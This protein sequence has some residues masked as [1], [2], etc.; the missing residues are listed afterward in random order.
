MKIELTCIR[1]CQISGIGVIE[2]DAVIKLDIDALTPRIKQ[3]FTGWQAYVKEKE[4]RAPL[5]PVAPSKVKPAV[6]SATAPAA[7]TLDTTNEGEETVTAATMETHTDV[8]AATPEIETSTTEALTETTTETPSD[9]SKMTIKEIKEILD[10]HGIA[11]KTQAT[12]TE[13]VALLPETE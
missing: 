6:H 8:D 3:F 9:A 11:Y 13:L 4:P 7:V 12:K 10:S 1:Q 2:R 5:K